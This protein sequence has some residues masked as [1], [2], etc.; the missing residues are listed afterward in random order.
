VARGVEAERAL[1]LREALSCYQSAVA[2][3]PANVEYI[4]RLAKQ[5]SDLT[6]E[7]GARNEAIVEANNKAIEYAERAVTLAPKSAAGHMA[8]CV[9]R[10]RLALVSDNKTKVRLAKEAR[11]AAVTALSLEPSNDLAHHLMGRW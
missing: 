8:L 1:D 7:P 6:Y 2:L 3:E 5:W 10:G 4:C 9:S 11:E